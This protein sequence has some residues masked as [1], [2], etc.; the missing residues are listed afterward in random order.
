VVEDGAE[1]GAFVET[2]NAH[3]GEQVTARHLAYLGDVDVGPRTNVGCGTITAN[4]DGR[5]KY[6]SDVGADAF[7]GAGTLL[8]APTSVGDGAMTG[9]GTVVTK[10][11]PVPAGETYVGIPARPLE[12]KT[13]PDRE[14][15]RA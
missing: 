15:T 4:W 11:H 13:P 6:H 14:G 5:Q 12:H 9:A 3:L 8:V 2:K 7:L 1:V 10:T